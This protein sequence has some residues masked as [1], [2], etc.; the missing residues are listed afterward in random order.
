MKKLRCGVG[1]SIKVLHAVT[2]SCLTNK[3]TY[4]NTVS[5]NYSQYLSLGLHDYF[6]QLQLHYT[7]EKL[8]YQGEIETESTANKTK[9]HSRYNR[10]TSALEPGDFHSCRRISPWSA[11]S[12]RTHA[13]RDRYTVSHSKRGT[14]NKCTVPRIISFM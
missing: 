2:I 14:V 5:I 13:R 3:Y 4:A 1:K 9:S 6:P 10:S 12:R 7:T 11:H 8:C